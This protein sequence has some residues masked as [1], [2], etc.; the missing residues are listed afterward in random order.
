[1]NTISQ[2]PCVQGRSEGDVRCETQTHPNQQANDLQWNCYFKDGIA[3]ELNESNAK[4]WLQEYSYSNLL[5]LCLGTKIPITASLICPHQSV[6]VQELGEL[7]KETVLLMLC[8]SVLPR[9]ILALPLS[10]SSTKAWTK[11][12]M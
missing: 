11:E 5:V 7:L 8:D 2:N 3:A 1:M 12:Q 4:Y 9:L 10:L 6:W